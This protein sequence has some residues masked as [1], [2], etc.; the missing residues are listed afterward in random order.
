MANLNV[1][2]DDTIKAQAEE[3]FAQIGMN[4]TTAINIFLR[5]AIE[6]G[7]VPFEVVSKKAKQSN[8]IDDDLI[9]ISAKHILKERIKVFEELAK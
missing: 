3:V 9:A 5:K 4:T 1:R 8:N 2:V 6:C 7:G